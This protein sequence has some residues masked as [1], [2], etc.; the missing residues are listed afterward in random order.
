VCG[1]YSNATLL[2]LFGATSV[3]T[4]FFGTILSLGAVLNVFFEPMNADIHI[5]LQDIIDDI[6]N[7]L[8]FVVGELLPFDKATLPPCKSPEI[9]MDYHLTPSDHKGIHDKSGVVLES[10]AFLLIIFSIY[11]A[12]YTGKMAATVEVQMDGSMKLKGADSNKVC[13]QIGATLIVIVGTLLAIIAACTSFM[14]KLDLNLKVY[15]NTIS[16]SKT[17]LDIDTHMQI[18]SAKFQP[19][20][21]FYFEIGAFV[22]FV[23][24][25]FY[26]YLSGFKVAINAALSKRNELQKPLMPYATPYSNQQQMGGNAPYISPVPQTASGVQP[27]PSQP[28]SVSW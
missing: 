28:Q 8:S 9:D 7:E 2:Q 12:Y 13:T 27:L 4:L 18:M 19:G 22:F 17:D 14:K 23:L 25:V 16:L 3:A 11:K 10:F 1:A 6:E 20:P 21:G 26:S 5:P 24:G 15:L